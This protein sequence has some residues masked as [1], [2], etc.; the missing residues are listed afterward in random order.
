MVRLA[1]SAHDRVSMAMTAWIGWKTSRGRSRLGRSCSVGLSE[2]LTPA[3]S[4]NVGL[5][6]QAIVQLSRLQWTFQPLWKPRILRLFRISQEQHVR[7]ERS[8][9][10]F[11]P[12]VS[13]MPSP[14]SRCADCDAVSACL[15]RLPGGV[16]DNAHAS[17]VE[18]AWACC[19]VETALWS[20][21]GSYPHVRR[22]ALCGNGS[23]PVGSLVKGLTRSR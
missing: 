14:R 18:D 4:R 23:H 12:R 15:L 17:K 6:V 1:Q 21:D 3:R 20:K 13:G 8:A 2:G 10:A 5:R 11:F 7:C 16:N 19:P 22:V 9:R